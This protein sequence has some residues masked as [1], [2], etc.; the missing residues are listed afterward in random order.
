MR[1]RGGRGDRRP[2]LARPLGREGGCHGNAVLHGVRTPAVAGG[3]LRAETGPEPAGAGGRGRRPRDAGAGVPSLP[4]RV[5]WVGG[6]PRPKSRA[7]SRR[8]PPL[9]PLPGAHRGWAGGGGP[10]RQEPPTRSEDS[11]ERAG[12]VALRQEDL[13]PFPSAC[14]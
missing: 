9:R 14:A 1:R 10:G 8:P 11:L 2:V 4:C 7:G 5:P 12:E 6:S 3:S 13:I